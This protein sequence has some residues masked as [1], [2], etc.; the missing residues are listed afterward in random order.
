MDYNWCNISFFGKVVLLWVVEFPNIYITVLGRWWSEPELFTYRVCGT[1]QF[2]NC[3]QRSW[4][5][6][7]LI[8]M[9]VFQQA[10]S[11]AEDSLPAD[12]SNSNENSS[13][14]YPLV[15]RTT[16]QLSCVICNYHCV[17]KSA[18]DRH[19][20]THT[21]EKPYACTHCG[22]KCTRSN[23][24][25]RHMAI[26]TGGKSFTCQYCNYKCSD[27]SNLKTHVRTHTGEK[28]YHCEHCDSKFLHAGHLKRHM[29]THTGEKPFNCKFCDQKCSQASGLK[30]HMM[31]HTGEKPFSCDQC[32]YKAAQRG[33]LVSHMMRKHKRNK[34]TIGRDKLTEQYY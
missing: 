27:A 34:I 2:S 20:R 3:H 13:I 1:L 15:Q 9:F 12:E 28:P 18:L 10:P 31:T 6:L 33:A 24:L 22:Y 21:G 19:M 8:C 7:L 32:E 17:Y 16:K 29:M 14:Q 5:T 23:H 11:E 26:H 30:L 25:K 4:E